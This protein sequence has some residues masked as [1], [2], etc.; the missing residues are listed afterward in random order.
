MGTRPLRG[1]RSS[2]SEMAPIRYLSVVYNQLQRQAHERWTSR[3]EQ[4]V[5][6]EYLRWLTPT[7]V[8]GGSQAHAGRTKA[9]SALLTQLRTGKIGFNAFLHEWKVPGYASPN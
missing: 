4:G 9:E 8:E 3:R 1:E 2:P 6:G 5:K 7:P